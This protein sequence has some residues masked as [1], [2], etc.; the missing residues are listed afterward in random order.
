MQIEVSDVPQ[1]GVR[2]CRE[3]CTA[4][5]RG[6]AAET[7][8]STG[9][10]AIDGRDSDEGQPGAVEHGDRVVGEKGDK[11]HDRRL[12]RQL[13]AEGG[14]GKPARRPEAAA[15]PRP[16][17]IDGDLGDDRVKDGVA[18]EL[19]RTAGEDVESAAGP[20]RD[21]DCRGRRRTG[22]PNLGSRRR[23]GGGHGTAVVGI[24]SP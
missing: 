24:P 11:L 7:E 3:E 16:P 23:M 18:L 9:R 5:K 17:V 14:Q 8:H 19:Q 2:G 10:V 15:M 6:H 21:G 4:D 20:D 1:E 22:D 13:E 12:D